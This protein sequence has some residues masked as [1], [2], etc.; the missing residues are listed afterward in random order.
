M[1]LPII[2]EILSYPV[3][4]GAQSHSIAVL[5]HRHANQRGIGKWRLF[6]AVFLIE[7]DVDGQ[8][9][10]SWWRILGIS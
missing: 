10:W 9:G 7:R 3:I 6:V 2:Q 1:R 4:D 8:V 5:A